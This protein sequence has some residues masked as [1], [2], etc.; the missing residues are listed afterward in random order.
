M[1][2][3]RPDYRPGYVGFFGGDFWETFMGGFSVVNGLAAVT[4]R[5]SGC[6]ND[7]EE[8]KE[9]KEVSL[10][11]FIR[12][13]MAKVAVSEAQERLRV[14]EGTENGYVCDFFKIT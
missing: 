4:G 6:Y 8:D 9:P 3:L 2:W 13:Q 5:G 11:S 10:G 12:G 1:D 7:N 14:G